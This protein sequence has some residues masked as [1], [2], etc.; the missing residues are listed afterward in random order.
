[1]GFKNLMIAYK[2]QAESDKGAIMLAVHR[3]RMSEGLNFSHEMS[4]AVILIGVPKIP[5]LDIKFKMICFLG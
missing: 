4:R 3:G 5:A 2:K 1:M